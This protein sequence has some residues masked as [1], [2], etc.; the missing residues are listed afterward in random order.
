MTSPVTR[1]YIKK[2]TEIG[3]CSRFFSAAVKYREQGAEPIFAGALPATSKLPA[4]VAAVVVEM[5]SL[6]PTI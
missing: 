4:E 1:R 3:T 2:L 5:T 6:L